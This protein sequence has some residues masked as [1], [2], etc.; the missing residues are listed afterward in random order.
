MGKLHCVILA[1]GKGTRIAP[2]TD[3]CAKSMVRIRERPFI[4]YQLSQLVAGGVGRVTICIGHLGDQIREF[5][6]NGKKWGIPVEYVDEG[7]TLRGTGGALRLAVDEGNL[8]ERF[9]VIYGD[10]FLPIRCSTVMDA[11]VA[12][13]RPALMTIFR[14]RGQWD[15]SNVHCT[16]GQLF[17]Y[18][19]HGPTAKMEYID[20]GLSA[21]H[22]SVIA[23][24]KHAELADLLHELSVAK[25]LAALEVYDRFYEVGSSD[26]LKDFTRFVT[27]STP[28]S[29]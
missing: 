6:G 14:N 17:L 19:K 20:Y 13:E 15:V 2:L 11:L 26:G 21:F 29:P 9:L 3:S 28:R 25:Q 22:R 12:S 5:V 24:S 7:D 16:K 10:S 8:P 4:D 23:T 18:D 27:R 1:G